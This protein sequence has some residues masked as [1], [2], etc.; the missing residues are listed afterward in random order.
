MVKLNTEKSKTIDKLM[1]YYKNV[2]CKNRLLQC[3][4]NLLINIEHPLLV[5]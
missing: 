5:T 2:D 3:L 1:L 4:K